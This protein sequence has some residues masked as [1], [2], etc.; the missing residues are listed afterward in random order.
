MRMTIKWTAK[1]LQ[2]LAFIMLKKKQGKF[3]CIAM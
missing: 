2:S 3:Y 1:Y